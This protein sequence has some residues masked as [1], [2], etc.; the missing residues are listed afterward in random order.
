MNKTRTFLYQLVQHSLFLSLRLL[1]VLALPGL[2]P[3]LVDLGDPL[4]HLLVGGPDLSLEVGRGHLG[5]GGG[6]G[7]GRAVAAVG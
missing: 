7:R 1:L 2:L 3:G 6:G 4:H 5:A